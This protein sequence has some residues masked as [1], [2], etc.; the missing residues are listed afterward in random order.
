VALAVLRRQGDRK[1]SPF[2]QR[3][4]AED[5]LSLV[6]PDQAACFENIQGDRE[7]PDHPLVNETIRDCL[8]GAMDI[9]GLE[10][11]L[12]AIERGEKQLV[13]RDLREPSPLAAE[14]LNARPYAFLDDAPLEERRTRAVVQRRWLDP[15]TASTLGALDAAAIAQVRQEAW[16]SVGNPDEMHDALLTLGYL[17]AQEIEAGARAT[18]VTPEKAP[19]VSGGWQAFLPALVEQGRVTQVQAAGRGFWVA[20]EWI[21][22]FRALYPGLEEAPPL[23]LP[24][25]LADRAWLPDTALA[26]LL[27]VRLAGTG[28]VTLAALTAQVGLPEV[29]VQGALIT[30]ESEGLLLQGRY[31]P[32]AEQAE[33][34]ERGLLARIHR[35]TLNRLRREIEPVTPADYLRFLAHWQRVEFDQRVTGVDGLAAAVEVLEG[36]EA[37]AAAWET[38]LLPARVDRYDPEWLERLCL[39]GRVVW[40][41]LTPP[42]IAGSR[43]WGPVATTPI[44]LLQRARLAQWAAL[45]EASPSEP[46]AL[47]SPARAVAEHLLG[48]GACFF[49]DLAAAAGLLPTQLEEALGELVNWG[50]VT[51]DNIAGIRA[52]ITPASKRP[53]VR[54]RG[55]LGTAAMESAGRWSLLPWAAGRI[56]P[57][58][59][60]ERPVPRRAFSLPAEAVEAYAM[61]LLRRYGVVFR[62]LLERERL[63]PAWYE[64]LRVYRL[65]EARGTVRGG[66]FVTGVSGEQY[67]L[68]EAVTQL[69]DLRRRPAVGRMLTVS[70]ADPL[71]LAG[72]VTPGGRVPA[73]VGN[74]VLYRDGEPLAGLEAGELVQ[75]V[76]LDEATQRACRA[77]LHQHGMDRVG[78][79]SG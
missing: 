44:A 20:A 38:E 14:I 67:A 35:Y 18:G 29:D 32:G 31:T 22:A 27:R 10:A 7:I 17:T 53:P 57:P 41:R 13:G 59:K 48:R 51:A 26:D 76:P 25:T 30:L 77:A 16:P 40:A 74:R 71:N 46:L 11:L 60:P 15:E 33:W 45:L 70:A 23:H 34:C 68:A 50:L 63:A 43:R 62:R 5:L 36:F 24:P 47:S 6:F 2:L 42:P 64:L 28:P 52:L 61:S 79:R 55:R 65:L 73:Y 1:V 3:M 56:H 66:R 4:K 49:D 37:P 9:A 12:G 39:S 19:A 75:L 54:M 72:I 58:P 8:E 78:R 21:G 69:R